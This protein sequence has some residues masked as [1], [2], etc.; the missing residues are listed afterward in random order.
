MFEKVVQKSSDSTLFLG[1]WRD[2]DSQSTRMKYADGSQ[3]WQGPH[4]SVTVDMECGQITQ[5]VSVSEP[6]LCEYL[7][8]VKTPAACVKDFS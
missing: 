8:I 1:Y 7:M 5:I 2:W 4:R 3:C 6:S